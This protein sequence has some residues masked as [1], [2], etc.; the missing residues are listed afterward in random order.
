LSVVSVVSGVFISYIADLPTGAT[1]VLVNFALFI[2][3]FLYKK[4]R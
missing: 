2:L 1:I 3:V 4:I